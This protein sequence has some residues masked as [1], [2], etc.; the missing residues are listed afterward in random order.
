MER[1]T[2]DYNNVHLRLLNGQA[3]A[4]QVGILYSMLVS[5]G[6][7][8][9]FLPLIGAVFDIW[10]RVCRITEPDLERLG[11]KLGHQRLLQSRIADS[12]GYPKSEPLPIVTT[13]QLP[14]SY[15]STEPLDTM[16]MCKQKDRSSERSQCFAI[17]GFGGCGKTAFALESA[18]HMRKRLSTGAVSGT[19]Q[20]G[21]RQR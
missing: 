1:E 2:T 12:Q 9:Y 18:Y 8:S 10:R 11:F 15:S 13:T 19:Q 7:Q 3:P 5:F 4:T 14:T 20:H 6:L 21:G 16:A 17:Y